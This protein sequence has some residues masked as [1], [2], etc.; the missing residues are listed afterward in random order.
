MNHG[1]SKNS[2]K[3]SLVNISK[4]KIDS[5]LY[6]FTSQ[7]SV[8]LLFVSKIDMSTKSVSFSKKNL[9]VLT[10]SGLFKNRFEVLNSVK[11]H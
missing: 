9:Y 10:P 5:R 8:Y 7:Q 2:Q 1:I 6:N 11:G 3:T 4:K